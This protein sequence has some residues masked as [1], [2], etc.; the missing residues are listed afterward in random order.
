MTNRERFALTLRGDS[1]VD[2]CPVMEW[3]LWWDKTIAGWEAEGLPKGLSGCELYDYFGLDR[4]LQFW[5]PHETPDCPQPKRHGAA[6]IESLD[7]YLAFKRYLYPKDAVRRMGGAIEA[8]LPQYRDGSGIVWYT[9]E[10]FFWYPRKLFG[11]EGHLYAFYDEPDLYHRI[12]EDLLEWQLSVVEEF[13]SIMAADFMTIA[14]DMSYNLGPMLSQEAYQAF[15]HPYYLRLIPEIK[16][17]QTRVILDSDGDISMSVPWFIESGIEG[18]LPLERQAGVDVG[19][20][21]RQYPEFLWLGGFD[22]M[23]LLVDQA[24]IDVEIARITPMLRRGRFIPSVDHQTPP[25]VTMENYRYYIKR[26][27]EVSVQA[28]KDNIAATGGTE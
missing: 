13:S 14:E 2:R 10:G 25:G 18:I 28:C 6:L 23:C 4:N 5:F 21:Q 8:A 3:A 7:D 11:I 22:K 9:L 16:K 26:L 17:R 12:C 1:A 20:L 24:A 15:I 19:A 27:H